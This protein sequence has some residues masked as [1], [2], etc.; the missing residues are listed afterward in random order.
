MLNFEVV[1]IP[2][3]DIKLN[4]SKKKGT[5]IS[6]ASPEEINEVRSGFDEYSLQNSRGENYHMEVAVNTDTER[7]IIYIAGASG[8][9][10]SYWA[11]RYIDAYQKAYPKRP[12]FVF[13]ALN[14][15][16]SIDK[17][18]DLQRINLTEAILQEDLPSS[19]F[20][21]ALVLMDDVDSIQNSKI[22]KK[23]MAIQADILQTGRHHNVS[24]I[25]TNHV[26]TNGRETR[27][28]LAEAHVITFFPSM[29]PSRMLKYLLENY[30]GLDRE[31]ITKVKNLPGR[32]V[33]YIKGFPRCLVSEKEVMILKMV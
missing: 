28:I 8:S 22:R 11:K 1:G 29:M 17:I 21:N 27:L 10:K 25:I 24:C 14:E 3:A 15:D 4:D 13:S 33:S 18:K 32:S 2:I 19:E 16:S 26:A 20:E 23:V 30:M 6:L 12:V 31:T 9:G 7:Q 5:L